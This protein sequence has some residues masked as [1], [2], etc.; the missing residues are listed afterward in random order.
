[1]PSH[2]RMLA[3]LARVALLALVAM[4]A[5]ACKRSSAHERDAVAPERA[6]TAPKTA[7]RDASGEKRAN[8][9]VLLLRGGRVLTAAGVVYERGDVLV[10]GGRIAAVGPGLDAPAGAEVIDVAGKT[11]T[12]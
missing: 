6:A 2:R 12:P 8:A 11:V 10:R 9:R 1:M 5:W 3:S 7:E 4:T